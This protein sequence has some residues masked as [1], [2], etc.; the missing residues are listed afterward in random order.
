[1][2]SPHIHLEAPQQN[3][4]GCAPELWKKYQPRISGRKQEMVKFE[5]E[6]I[7]KSLTLLGAC[8][9]VPAAEDSLQWDSDAFPLKKFS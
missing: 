6:N 4:Y 1:M 3:G 5:A 8:K 7:Q 2:S 9:H